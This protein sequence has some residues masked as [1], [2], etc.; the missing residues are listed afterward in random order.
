M[1]TALDLVRNAKALITEVPISQAQAACQQADII[2]DVR[3]PAEYAAGHIKG[4]VSVPRGVLEFKI[5]D[6]PAI[7]GA[8]THIMLYCK[9]SGRAALAAQSLALLGYQQVTSITGGYEAWVEADMPTVR[10]QD[11]VDFG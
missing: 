10:P 1:K 7:K 5:A 9:T 11:G 6:L 3:E 8:D 4:A 2:I